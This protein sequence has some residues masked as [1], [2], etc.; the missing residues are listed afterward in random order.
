[1]NIFLR[2]LSHMP[3][4][5]GFQRMHSQRKIFTVFQRDSD[6]LEHSKIHPS[7]TLNQLE[8]FINKKSLVM[9]SD[10]STMTRLVSCRFIIIISK[11][12]SFQNFLKQ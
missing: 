10:G 7:Y 11:V 6:T 3:P 1:M 2:T 12:K 4:R 9:A 5:E 8:A